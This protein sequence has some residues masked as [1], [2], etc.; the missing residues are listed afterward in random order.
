VVDYFS[1]YVEAE[2]VR[3]TGWV[4]LQPVLENMFYRLGYPLRIKSDNGPPFNG[5][6]YKFYCETRGIKPT[7][8]APLNPQQNGAAEAV[9]KHINRAAQN[10][11]AEKIDIAK[12]LRDR[13]QAHNSATHSVTKQIPSEVLFGRRL[14][15]GLPMKRPAAT[16]I[17]TETMRDLDWKNK[18]DKKES[19]D[20]RRHA[21]SPDI[22]PGD[23]VV[24]ERQ[25][26]RKGDTPF[27]PTELTVTA[28]ENGDLTLLDPNG[29]TRYRDITK[30]KKVPPPEDL[31][32]ERQEEASVPEA[33]EVSPPPIIDDNRPK[34]TAKPTHRFGNFVLQ[35]VEEID[36]DGDVHEN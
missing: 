2:I 13:I 9:M 31:A 4:H 1:R 16:Q 35:A 33:R 24:L 8:S 32:L 10:A 27:D 26:K 18:L 34:R 12:A 7:F 28:R 29:K 17:D 36:H 11:S 23:K 30:V 15:T 25:V 5:D 21:K 3:S 20:K 6:Q 14:R 19:E 22:E